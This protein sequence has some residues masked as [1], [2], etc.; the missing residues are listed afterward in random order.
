MAKATKKAMLNKW[1]P[2]RDDAINLAT[3]R[4][5]ALAI[6]AKGIE[7]YGTNH[8]AYSNILVALN[9]G[10][11]AINAVDAKK[12]PLGDDDIDCPPGWV[13][14]HDDCAPSCSN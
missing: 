10:L 8:R 9:K 5:F 4:W 12:P 2:H 7:L 11:A 1:Q 13:P 3:I 14:C 6:E